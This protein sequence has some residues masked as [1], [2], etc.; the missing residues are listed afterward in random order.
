MP[1][2]VR[3]LDGETLILQE[4]GASRRFPMSIERV[5]YAYA[6][7]AFR[8]VG[9]PVKAPNGRLLYAPQPPA[10]KSKAPAVAPPVAA[11]SATV[12]AQLPT[13]QSSGFALYV[14]SRYL[15]R[16]LI[17]HALQQGDDGLAERL[18]RNLIEAFGQK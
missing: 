15:F 2:T 12:V 16:M 3:A 7:D 4:L 14:T 17:E 5:P 11:T 9:P 1:A 8:E 18:E 10:P 6:L 13:V